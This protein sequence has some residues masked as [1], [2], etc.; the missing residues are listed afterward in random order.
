M[1]GF[2]LGLAM[3]AISEIS[4]SPWL[5]LVKKQNSCLGPISIDTYLIGLECSPGMGFLPTCP[6]DSEVPLRLLGTTSLWKKVINL[7]N[8]CCMPGTV[9]SMFLH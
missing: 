9:L 7:S 1:H 4:E 3:V 6:D 5:Y 2:G 8:T